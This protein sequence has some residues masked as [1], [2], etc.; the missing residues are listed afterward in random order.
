M[1][2]LLEADQST[3]LYEQGLWEQILAD[4]V[5]KLPPMKVKVYPNDAIF[6]FDSLDELRAFDRS[7]IG[8]TNSIIMKNIAATLGC[9]QSDIL[10]FCAIKEGL[11][12]IPFS[13]EANG[14]KY[15]YRHPGE[16]T[17]KIIS[18]SHEKKALELAR[19][20]GVDST[21]L[22]MDDAEGWKLSRFVEGIRNPEYGSFEDSLLVITV[23][24]QLH[25]RKLSVEWSFQPWE[26]ACK[27]T[28]GGIADRDFDDLK[29]AVQACYLR[30]QNDG[31]EPRFCHC[32]TYAPNWMLTEDGRTIL[33]YWVYAGNA[34]PG[35]DIG[36]Y[37]HMEKRG[38]RYLR[39][40]LINAAKYVCHWEPSFAAYLAKKRAEG[41][42]YNVAISHAAKKLV[43]LIFALQT[44]GMAYQSA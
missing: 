14:E 42:H 7:Y 15:V 44:S 9:E 1:S 20:I 28:A 8:D 24:R 26:E 19:S 41:K 17:E 31:V 3:S 2:A 6:E 37:A 11:T 38:Y 5:K 39:Y 13:F 27:I 22:Y 23:L 18:R 21:F 34:D 4:H 10:H 33:I 32:D 36:A 40:A 25:D 29:A 35:C 43:R 16:G 30:C 12:N